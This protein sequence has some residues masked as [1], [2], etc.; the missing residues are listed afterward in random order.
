MRHLRALSSRQ[1]SITHCILQL[2]VHVGNHLRALALVVSAYNTGV[3]SLMLL[4]M[5]R[6]S[7]GCGVGRL[8][9]VGWAG[10]YKGRVPSFW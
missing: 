9:A 6:G 1:D 2:H 4:S 5:A 8:W 7:C 10:Q 3:S